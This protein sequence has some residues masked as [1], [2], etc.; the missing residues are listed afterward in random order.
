MR[1]P[2]G[3]MLLAGSA[4]GAAVGVQVSSGPISDL[5]VALSDPGFP[6]SVHLF[7][8]IQG[9]SICSTIFV[10]GIEYSNFANQSMWSDRE[11]VQVLLFMYYSPA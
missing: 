4:L 7:D 3:K 6:G 10:P 8:Q 11:G 9:L 2:V 5:G 1:W